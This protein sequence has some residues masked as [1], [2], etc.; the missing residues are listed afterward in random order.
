LHDLLK[1]IAHTATVDC[2]PQQTRTTKNVD[3][4]EEQ[5]LGL[6]QKMQQALKNVVRHT[7]VPLRNYSLTYLRTKGTHL[8]SAVA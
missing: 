5:E 4:V 2:K 7:D 1:N 3:A 8:T 6:S